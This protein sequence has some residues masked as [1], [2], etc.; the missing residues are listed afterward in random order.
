[1]CVYIYTHTNNFF[2]LSLAHIHTFALPIYCE[3]PANREFYCKSIYASLTFV[4]RE[5][6]PFDQV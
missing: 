4:E 3:F 1:M 5:T 6:A 2:F